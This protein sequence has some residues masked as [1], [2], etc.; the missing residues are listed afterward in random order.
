MSLAAWVGDKRFEIGTASLLKAWFS[1]IYVRLEQEEWGALF[2]TIMGD[3][4]AGSVPHGRA[5]LALE[6]LRSVREALAALPPDR[7]V[8]DFENREAVPPWG[9]RISERIRT[10]GEYFVSSDGKDLFDVLEDA[11]GEAA[12]IKQDVVIS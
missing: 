7:V 3:L 6:E 11:L 8:W 4:Y 9:D 5:E 12:T 1:T 10:L 2:P